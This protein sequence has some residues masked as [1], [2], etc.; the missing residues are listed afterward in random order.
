VDVWYGC[1]HQNVLELFGVVKI[2]EDVYMVSPWAENGTL[3]E[4]V[5]SNPFTDRVH[6]VRTINAIC[7]E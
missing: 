3:L 4:F 1:K 6:L 7:S 2:G 5:N